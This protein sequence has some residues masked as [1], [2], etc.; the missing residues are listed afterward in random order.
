MKIF[1]LFILITV[2]VDRASSK[3]IE[4]NNGKRQ[5]SEFNE[6]SV[7][8]KSHEFWLKIVD[9]ILETIRN[10]FEAQSAITT[11]IAPIEAPSEK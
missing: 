4:G 10:L 6:N 1:V 2:I 3:N 8:T 7:F 5:F 11:T 9:C